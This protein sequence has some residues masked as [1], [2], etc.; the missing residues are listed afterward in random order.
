M[1]NIVINPFLRVQILC[2]LNSNN[3]HLNLNN[4]H[5]LNL[6]V[7]LKRGNVTLKMSK[8]LEALK[9]S[10]KDSHKNT[11]PTYNN[12]TCLLQPLLCICCRNKYNFVR[13]SKYPSFGHLVLL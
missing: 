10:Q 12:I 5:D 11:H 8:N 13:H 3:T 6:V 9:L 4:S 7:T 2:K 1:Y